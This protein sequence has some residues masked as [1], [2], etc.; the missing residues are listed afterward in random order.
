MPSTSRDAERAEQYAEVVR[1]LIQ[2]A[3]ASGTEAKK[4]GHRVP[5]H[6]P[7]HPISYNYHV[8]PSDWRGSVQVELHGEKFEVLLARTRN[9]VFGRCEALWAEAMGKTDEEMFASLESLVEPLFKRQRTISAALGIE[10]RFTGHFKELDNAQLLKLLYCEDRDVASDALTTLE[11]RPNKPDLLPALI[12]IIR[13]DKHPY[14]RSAQWCVLDLFEDLP[15]YCLTEAD[16]LEAISAI[17]NLISTATD[18]YARTIYKAGVVLGGHLPDQHG[19]P[20]L[21]SCLSAPSKYGR[22]SSIHGLF[23]VVE[24]NPAMR[25]EVVRNLEKVAKQDS[26]P[27][28]REYAS[29]M[30]QD[31]AG[32]QLDHIPE[33]V[34]PEEA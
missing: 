27:L 16:E 17:Q 28:L 20:A 13:D 21:I 31:I 9:R 10:G 34:F 19:G 3:S 6:W 12:E 2:K 4:P 29:L 1:A 15:S 32:E 30:A 24:W 14:R 8:L 5:F 33:P 18:D 26:E 11:T 22:R 23:H 7:P 25:E